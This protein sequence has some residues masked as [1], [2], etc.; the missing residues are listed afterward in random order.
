MPKDNGKLVDTETIVAKMVIEPSSNMFDILGATRY[1]SEKIT[2]S[3]EDLYVSPCA[4]FQ[5]DTDSNLDE[6]LLATKEDVVVE[7]SV[8]MI[9][10]AQDETVKV[11]NMVEEVGLLKKGN[12]QWAPGRPP[13]G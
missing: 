5:K 3:E 10:K 8:K 11:P 13:K 4:S 7:A 1:S 9:A 6:N 2:V 12:Q